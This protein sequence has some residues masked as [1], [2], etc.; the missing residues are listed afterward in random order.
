M[1][2]TKEYVDDAVDHVVPVPVLDQRAPWSG[3]FG[4]DVSPTVATEVEPIQGFDEVSD[5]LHHRVPFEQRCHEC[6]GDMGDGA[7]VLLMLVPTT[8]N[9]A[10][11]SQW[12]WR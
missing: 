6:C 1:R 8:F 7:V 10:L 9:N 5:V 11:V 3:G 2:V 4:G 12:Q